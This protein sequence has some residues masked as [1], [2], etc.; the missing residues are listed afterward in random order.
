MMLWG[1]DM[2]TNYNQATMGFST[3]NPN[4][5]A[6]WD[7]TSAVYTDLGWNNPALMVYQESHDDE[8]LQYNNETYGN[9]NGAYNIM[10]TAIGLKR[11]EAM[12]AIWAFIPGPH[13]LTEFGEL[14]FDYSVNWCPN[15]TV[16]P[17]GTC[18]TDPKPIRWDYLQDTSRKH[19]H[20]VYADLLSIRAAYPDL[21]NATCTYSLS[22]AFKYVTLSATDLS[23]V[24]VA[25][26]D[27]QTAN[28][29]V[30][31]P[32]SGTYYDYFSGQGFAATGSAQSINLQAGEYHIYL[33]Q[34]LSLTTPVVSV[35]GP[36]D[37]LFIQV[38]PNPA[39]QGAQVQY[40]VPDAGNATMTLYNVLGQPLGTTDLGYAGAHAQTVPLQQLTGN[41]FLAKG[42]YWI[43]L[44]EGNNYNYCMFVQY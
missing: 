4:N 36:D 40:S 2:N 35:P 32:S 26:F 30:T 15:G 11:N 20:D 28:A 42:V 19:L 38:Q 3:A 22:G 5:G 17:T 43:R 41:A 13:M 29:N 10:D 18:R 14:G 34:D 23:V 39:T 9:S 8:R 33:S 6:T 27:V 25:N 37:S 21:A 7:L 1:E 24:V 12:T 44:T 16:D 31:F